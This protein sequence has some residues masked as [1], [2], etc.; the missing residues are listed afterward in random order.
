[1]RGGT[2]FINV[3]REIFQLAMIKE[4]NYAI[5]DLESMIPFERGAYFD[6]VEEYREEQKKL[7][8]KQEQG[9]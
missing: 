4:L 7:Q 8:Q 9:K 1:M 6:L 5:I 3:V 2:S